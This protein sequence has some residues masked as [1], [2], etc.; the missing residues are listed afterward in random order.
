MTLLE[1]RIH[2]TVRRRYGGATAVD[3]RSTRPQLAQRLLGGRTV[4]EAARLVETLFALCS[5]SQRIAME[6][7][8]EAARGET[9]SA[10]LVEQRE[11]QVLA[12]LA[13]EHAWLLLVHVPDL[14]GH[15]RDAEPLLRLRQAGDQA[16]RL[17]T[18]LTEVLDE[19]VLGTPAQHWLAGSPADLDRWRHER[20]T[21]PA[22]MLAGLGDGLDTGSA[23]APVLPAVHRLG[24]AD[25]SPLARQALDE[26]EFCARPLWR[27]IPAE[28]GAAA[29]MAEEPLVAA[30]NAARGR[31]A[32]ARLLARIAELAGLPRRLRE[33]GPSLVRAWSLGGGGGAAAVETSRGLLLHVL[34]LDGETIS[35]YRIVAPTEWNFHPRGAL[36][37]GLAPWPADGDLAARAR[38]IALSLDPCVGF[39]VELREA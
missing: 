35:D 14:T 6:A 32:G 5:R 4:A 34:R 29:R 9:P 31:G 25:L 37:E 26:P 28:T 11:R 33:G 12:E 24:A 16:E 27:G 17:A 15:R 36:A 20:G 19:R 13:R 3:I 30:W 23:H 22:T 39:D 7:A 10:A 2:I 21:V 8:A 1:G 38:L 18:V